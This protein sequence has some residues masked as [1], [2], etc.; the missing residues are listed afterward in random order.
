MVPFT[1]G[2]R[3]T[4][5]WSSDI[6]VSGMLIG[7]MTEALDLDSFLKKKQKKLKS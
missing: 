5:V 2:L 4:V 1:E 3:K 6:F 7:L